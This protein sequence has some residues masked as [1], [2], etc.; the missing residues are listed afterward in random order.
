LPTAPQITENLE[1]DALQLQASCR[2]GHGRACSLLADYVPDARGVLDAD[3]GH[4][5]IRVPTGTQARRTVSSM[6]FAWTLYTARWA[7]ALYEAD[8]RRFVETIYGP[9][10]RRSVVREL[11][12]RGRPKRII[13]YDDDGDRISAKVRNR[14][15]AW[16]GE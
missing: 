14:A 16:I 1:I 10:G 4:A 8:K 7:C 15:G 12:G 3:Q 13:T 6:T 9:K 5:P 11:D 2:A